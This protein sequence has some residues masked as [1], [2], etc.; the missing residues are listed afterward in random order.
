MENFSRTELV[1]KDN[2][3]KIK[4]LKILL[5]G[6]GGVG[7]FVFELLLRLGVKEITI[8]DCDKFEESNLNRQ[9]LCKYKNLGK[10]KVEEAIKRAKE[11]RKDVKIEGFF[12]RVTSE[13]VKKF[14]IGDYDFVIDCID[15]TKA[16]IAIILESDKK[17]IPIVCAMGTGNRY[18]DPNFIV[19]DINKTSYDRLSKKIRK[20]LKKYKL[21]NKVFACY[22]K[23]ESE[24]TKSLGSVVYSPFLCAGKIVSFVTNFIVA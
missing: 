22:S 7:G 12:E 15:D 16:K 14:F 2:F 21:K 13:N 8:V 4:N 18:K 6:L 10:S 5:F 3:E 19:D 1:L 23:T 24:K 20:E 11:I 9:L 17:N